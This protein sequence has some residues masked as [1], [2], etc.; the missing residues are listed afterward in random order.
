MCPADYF[1][2]LRHSRRNAAPFSQDSAIGMNVMP[3]LPVDHN[4]LSLLIRYGLVIL[5]VSSAKEESCHTTC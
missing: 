5:A 4:L 2:R 3:A 1:Y